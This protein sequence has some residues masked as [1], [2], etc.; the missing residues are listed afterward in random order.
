MG[1]GGRGNLNSCSFGLGLPL[2][3]NSVYGLGSDLGVEKD[4]GAIL[5]R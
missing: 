1:A 5:V 2:L 4:W 3:F